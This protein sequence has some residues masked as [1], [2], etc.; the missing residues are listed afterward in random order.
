MSSSWSEFWQQKNDFDESMIDNYQF[1]L[2]KVESYV[3]PDASSRVLDIGSGPGHL[4]DAWH[5]R[6]AEIHGLDI[7]ERYNQIALSKHNNHPHVFF[8]HLKPDDFL[9][10]S[11][12][13]NKK[14]D[15]IIVMSVLQYYPDKEK[16]KE[17]LKTIQQFAAPGAKLLLC[18]LVV[19]EGMLKDLMSILWES[20]WKGRLFSML[21]FLF[22]L[23][24]SK[25]YQ[26]KKKEGFLVIREEEWSSL[27][28]EL[29]LQFEFLQEPITLQ[30][31]RKTIKVHF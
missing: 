19:H 12:L 27:L 10:F 14:F 31:D 26:I 9:N 3:Q 7:S 22:K 30:K 1:F 20:L 16:V 28:H 13:G 21:Q 29:Q 18:D 15:I 25:Y 24:F 17:L 6:V 11:F 5:N 8:H 2:S 4:E 23:R